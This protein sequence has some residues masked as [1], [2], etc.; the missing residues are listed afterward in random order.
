MARFLPFGY[1]KKG[2]CL[3][4]AYWPVPEESCLGDVPVLAG[5]APKWRPV[6]DLHLRPRPHT[7]STIHRSL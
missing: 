3:Q 2:R 4:A 6:G 5:P 1:G 7:E